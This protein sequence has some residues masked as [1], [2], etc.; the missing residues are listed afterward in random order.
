LEQ[1]SCAGKLKGVH[2]G[3]VLVV[4]NVTSKSDKNKNNDLQQFQILISQ[5]NQVETCS[6]ASAAHAELLALQDAPQM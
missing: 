3:A 6:D 4:Q 2:I 5:H 1:V